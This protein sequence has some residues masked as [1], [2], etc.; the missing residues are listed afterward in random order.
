MSMITYQSEAAGAP[1]SLPSLL[2]RM[3]DKMR[4]MASNGIAVTVDTLFEHSDF[5]RGEIDSFARE[6]ADL[7]RAGRAA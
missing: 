4:E 1:T 3:A 6:A 7:A 2:E 5:T